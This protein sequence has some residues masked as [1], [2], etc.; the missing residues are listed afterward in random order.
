MDYTLD[1]KPQGVDCYTTIPS[2]LQDYT[3]FWLD[4]Y[5]SDEQS[6]PL[7]EWPKLYE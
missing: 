1:G 7:A 6:V 5:D 2:E 3:D 4:A